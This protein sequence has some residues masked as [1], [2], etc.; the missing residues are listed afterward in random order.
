MNSV[1]EKLLEDEISRQLV[2]RGGYEVCKIGTEPD[3]RHDFDAK[4]G[5]DLAELQAFIDATQAEAW[6]NLVQAHGGDEGHASQR[7]L[8]R[9][10]Q[11][12][13]ER[14]SVD[15]IRHGVRDQNVEIRLSYRRP[16]FGV[17][18]ELVAH[19]AANR[20]TVTRQLPYD[21]DST[22]TVDLVCFSTESLSRPPS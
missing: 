16:A 17:A 7:F 4:L 6:Q 22:K 11:Q 18:Q 20:L 13:D 12:I 1:S 10:A 15:V 21:P 8:Q 14:G 2:S 9:L 19:Y 3:Y 5:L